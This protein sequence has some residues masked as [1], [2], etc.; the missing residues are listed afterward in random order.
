MLIFYIGVWKPVFFIRIGLLVFL[1]FGL[2]CW[3]S[4]D[5]DIWFSLGFGFVCSFVSD[6]KLAKV[7]LTANQFEDSVV[8]LG[9]F[10]CV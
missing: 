2:V 7:F 6:V 4:L 1:G 3:F 8:K 9:L 5:L 10:T